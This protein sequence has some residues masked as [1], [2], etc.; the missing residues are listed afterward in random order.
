MFKFIDVR[1]I[2]ISNIVFK[3]CG[4]SSKVILRETIMVSL[5]LTFESTNDVEI[6]DTVIDK[7]GILFRQTELLCGTFRLFNLNLSS[8][9]VG[10]YYDTEGAQRED[11]YDICYG[12]HLQNSTLTMSM[13]YMFAVY[14]E[15]NIEQVM[16]NQYIGYLAACMLNGHTI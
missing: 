8:K 15:V 1:G 6:A 11:F 13:I 9:G 12:F 16:M 2:N 4:A 7:G 14:M 5:T 3:S 10:T